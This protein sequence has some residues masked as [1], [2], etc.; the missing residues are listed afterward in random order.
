MKEPAVSTVPPIRREI[1]VD[2]DPVTAFEAFTE[3]IGRWWPLAELSVY[4]ASATVEFSSGQ[5]IERSA[6]G[7][8]S[9]GNCHPVGAASRGGIHLASGR[10]AGPGQPR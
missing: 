1:L 6:D 2:A 5:I 3:R 9:R 7:Q 4:G 10:D 8:S